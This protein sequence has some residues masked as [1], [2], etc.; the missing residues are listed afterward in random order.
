MTKLNPRQQTFV[1][2]YLLDLNA[3][4]AAIRAG[5]S[6]RGGSGGRLLK[7]DAVRGVVREAMLRRSKRT[8]ISQDRILSELA[9]IAFGDLRDVA[10]WGADGVRLHDST[11]LSTE[12][13]ATL[14]EVS[15]SAKGLLKVKR[16]DKVKAL[17]LLMRHLGML[18]EK[19][20]IS[21]DLDITALERG[22]ER[23]RAAVR[24]EDEPQGAPLHPAAEPD[25]EPAAIPG[26]RQ[27][28]DTQGHAHG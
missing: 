12:Q 24:D 16:H 11:G 2:E 23:A 22:R 6:P 13:A 5:Y 26:G 10:A 19:L 25:T 18:N 3:T 20:H 14:A 4:Q 27:S 8:A 17:E 9:C 21:A 15:E 28:D 1:A 7:S